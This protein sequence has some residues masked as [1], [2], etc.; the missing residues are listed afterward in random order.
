MEAL[1]PLQERFVEEM[2]RDPTSAVQAYLRAGGKGEPGSS[3]RQC[4]ARLLADA[5]V[6]AALAAKRKARAE[7]LGYSGD[8][9]VM[10]LVEVVE[11]CMTRRPVLDAEG[12]PTGEYRFDT[13]GAN[14]ALELLGKHYG[15][16]EK[17][18]AQKKELTHEDVAERKRQL[19]E[20]GIDLDKFKALS[21]N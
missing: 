8:W 9:V 17:H 3:A 10:C 18:N 4:A 21:D 5:G 7:R 19:K 6:S 2:D 11:R 20:R 14:K 13:A 12:A 1:T 16:F 15:I